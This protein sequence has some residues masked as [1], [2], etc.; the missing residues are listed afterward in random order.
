MATMLAQNVTVERLAK[1]DARIS[2]SINKEMM[3]SSTN[4]LKE[5]HP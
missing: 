4:A 2:C 5:E 1:K 3:D